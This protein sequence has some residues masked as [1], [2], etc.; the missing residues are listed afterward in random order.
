[1]SRVEADHLA[2]EADYRTIS[3]FRKRHLKARPGRDYL[4]TG[5]RHHPGIPGRNHPVLDGRLRRNRHA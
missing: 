4:V 2:R 1:M 3:D 5:G